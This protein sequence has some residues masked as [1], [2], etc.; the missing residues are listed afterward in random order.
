MNIVMLSRTKP[1]LVLPSFEFGKR[2][3]TPAA[4]T[5]AST[6]MVI[7]CASSARTRESAT[8]PPLPGD[9]ATES[10]FAA[11]SRSA[12]DAFC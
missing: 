9:G 10:S 8:S 5:G 6:L 2:R 1:V 3:R 4:A 11:S 7:V 12:G